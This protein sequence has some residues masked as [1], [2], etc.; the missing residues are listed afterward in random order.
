MLATQEPHR[1]FAG[2]VPLGR[3]DGA[4]ITA[5]GGSWT[6]PAAVGLDTLKVDVCAVS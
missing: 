4:G 1:A 2:P 5:E 6:I 3:M